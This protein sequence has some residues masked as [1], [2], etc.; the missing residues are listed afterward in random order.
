MRTYSDL[1]RLAGLTARQAEHWTRQGYIRPD[2]THPGSG[3]GRRYTDAEFRI[4]RRM[5][6]LARV[7]FAPAD[8]AKI[9]RTNAT[10]EAAPGISFDVVDAIE[11]AAHAAE[12][13]TQPEVA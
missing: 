6:R 9:A 13:A 1:V 12:P 10:W 4:A 11:A 5:A 3:H 2:T 8:A 7:G